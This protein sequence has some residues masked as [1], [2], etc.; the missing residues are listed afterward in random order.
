MASQPIICPTECAKAIVR[1]AVT[2]ARVASEGLGARDRI[3]RARGMS[4][5]T[6]PEITARI[7]SSTSDHNSDVGAA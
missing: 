7:D 5:P 4:G 3:R 1:T 2:G 6:A